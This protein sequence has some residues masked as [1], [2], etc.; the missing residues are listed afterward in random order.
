MLKKRL[1]LL[2]T[3]QWV[4]GCSCCISLKLTEQR[5]SS[6][7]CQKIQEVLNGQSIKNQIRTASMHVQLCGSGQQ[8]SML[9]PDV[10]DS[11]PQD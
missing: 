2:D 4:K 10:I 7:R 11:M 5:Q 1:K 6:K 8:L 9:Q 3:E